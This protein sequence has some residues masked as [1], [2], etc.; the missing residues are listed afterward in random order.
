[1]PPSTRSSGWRCTFGHTV[2]ARYVFFVLSVFSPEFSA[3][4]AT[5]DLREAVDSP[6][7]KRERTCLVHDPVKNTPTCYTPTRLHIYTDTLSITTNHGVNISF[8]QWPFRTFSLTTS[9]YP[10]FRTAACPSI[11][12]KWR[13][14]HPTSTDIHKRHLSGTVKAK[15]RNSKMFRRRAERRGV[16]SQE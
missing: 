7:T 12:S 15:G 3:H 2:K 9:P 14:I 10:L 16:L 4:A 1:M 6:K 13:A 8:R 11:V 5:D